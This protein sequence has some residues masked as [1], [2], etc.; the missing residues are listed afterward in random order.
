M[1]DEIL[2]AKASKSDGERTA[3]DHRESTGVAGGTINPQSIDSIQD[4]RFVQKRPAIE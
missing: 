1:R 2:V 4:E 3:D